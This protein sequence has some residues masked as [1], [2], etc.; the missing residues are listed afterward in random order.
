MGCIE[1]SGLRAFLDG[2]LADAELVR[3]EE[4]VASCASCQSELEAL[5]V[6]ASLAQ[7]ALDRMAPGATEAP[8]PAW[9]RIRDRAE[10]R[11]R[12]PVTLGWG[13]S[14]MFR[15]LFGFAGGSPV[16]AAVSTAAALAIVA[17]LFTLS[18]VQTVA[19]SFLSIF[20]VQK[21]VAVQVDPTS[22]P[23]MAV[24]TDLGS[25]T[26]TGQH[27]LKVVTPQEA[28]K[29]VGLGVPTVANLPQPLQ[30]SPAAVMVTGSSSV[31][32]TPDIKKVRA[33]LSSIGATNVQL[34][35][36]LDGKPITLQIPAA[37]SVLYLERGAATRNTEG[38]PT[39]AVGQQFLYL[40][41]ATSP[42]MN[43]PDG[44]DV[45]QIRSEV[46][47]IPGLPADLVNQLKAIDDWRNTVVVPVVKG[48]SHEVTVQ[49]QTGV[50]ISQPDSNGTTLMWAK[51][52]KV[53]A[54]SGS[55]SE[56]ELLA[57]ANSLK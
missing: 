8:R 19:S 20:R 6:N 28:E 25:F 46:L 57:V 16:R 27:S 7:S 14:Q 55:F 24:P 1:R 13:L 31:T 49:G 30:P 48:T 36:S 3:V 45:D 41:V 5:R 33:Y 26:T 51:D 12:R 2:E 4:H 22:L 37:M 56:S 42:T 34:P 54:V 32:F 50:A 15:N 10:G 44:V 35:D 47:K 53:Y 52:G 40:G 17:L 29:V 18:P 43:V 39:P 9:S 11:A 23:K 21:F 38:I